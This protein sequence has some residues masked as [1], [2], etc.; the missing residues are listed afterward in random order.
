VAHCTLDFRQHRRT[1]KKIDELRIEL[2]CPS[3][4][5][6]F[7]SFAEAAGMT[8]APPMRDRV[9]AVGDGNDSGRE[10]YSLAF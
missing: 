8:V 10:R 2:G 1:Q 9:E 5:N 7:H 6:G 3:F 4:P